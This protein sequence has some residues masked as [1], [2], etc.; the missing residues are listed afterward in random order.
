MDTKYF[1]EALQEYCKK[2]RLDSKMPL[3]ASVLSQVLLRAQ[4]LKEEDRKRLQDA[5]GPNT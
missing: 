1:L 2:N 3:C 4:E 5:G